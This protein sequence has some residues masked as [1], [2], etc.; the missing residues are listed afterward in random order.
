MTTCLSDFLTD[1]KIGFREEPDFFFPGSFLPGLL[2]RIHATIPVRKEG[3]DY[4]T[5]F[6]KK[7][8]SR[9]NA[10]LAAAAAEAS[11]APGRTEGGTASENGA[12]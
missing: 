10:D 8:E 7:G 9:K 4:E 2:Y 12:G 1:W 3:T 11:A 6:A 5:V